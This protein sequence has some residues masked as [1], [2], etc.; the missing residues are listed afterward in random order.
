MLFSSAFS[1]TLSATN[2]SKQD[3]EGITKSQENDFHCVL[4]DTLWDAV[5]KPCSK[6]ASYDT[7]QKK[8][9]NNDFITGL[10]KG[11]GYKKKVFFEDSV[12]AKENNNNSLQP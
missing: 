7:K 5:L 4:K 9:S 12:M 6:H 10:Q 8:K 2:G 11:Q 1:V 3:L